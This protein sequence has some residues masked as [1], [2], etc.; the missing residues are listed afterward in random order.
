LSTQCDWLLR[1]G[2]E[3][4]A[5]ALSQRNPDRAENIRA[6]LHRLTTGDAMGQL[7]KVLAIHSPEWPA[8][9]GFA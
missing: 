8:P 1:L 6:A 9:A 4:R 5:A 7:F 3:A 2:I